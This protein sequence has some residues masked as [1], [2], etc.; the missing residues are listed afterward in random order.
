M[1]LRS[2]LEKLAEAVIDKAE[3]DSRSFTE[4]VDALKAVTTLYGILAKDKSR[5]QGEGE[6]GATMGDFQRLIESDGTAN[7]A[8]Q[9]PGRA[10]RRGLA[11][12]Q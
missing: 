1:S 4:T 8:S 5:L 9:I 10:G 6:P 11:G 12:P 3:E 2:R 7:A